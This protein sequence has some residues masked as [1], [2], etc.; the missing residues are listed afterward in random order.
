MLLVLVSGCVNLGGGAG[1]GAKPPTINSF[2]AS[3]SP[4]APGDTSMLS[5]N[6]SGATTIS[7]NQGIGNVALTGSRTVTPS[8]T[9]VYILTATNA[10][11]STTAT[12]EV[13]VSAAVA[14]PT[15]PAP[16][17]TPPVPE[18]TPVPQPSADLPV[19]N[20]FN[21]NPAFI[22]SGGTT[23]LSWGV[24][25]ATQV[26]IDQGIGNVGMVG[27][28]PASPV[29]TTNYTLTATNAA[30]WSSVTIT[31][32]V[33]AAPPPANK[34][35]LVITDITL[36]G[37]TIKYVIKNQGTAAA[38]ASTAQLVIDGVAKATGA[39]GPLS[40]GASSTLSFGYSY[41]CS[42]TSDTVAVG[43]DVYNVVDEIN[44]GN[45]VL[46]K[47][48]S[49]LIMLP[50]AFILSFKPDLI[51]TDI[52]RDGVT[53]RYRIK[54]QGSGNAVASTT[55]LIVDG[56]VKAHDNVP[57]LVAGAEST[58]SFT[59]VLPFLPFHTFHVTVR[60]DQTNVVTESNEA[61]NERT[62]SMHW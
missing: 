40:A 32:G 53:I 24:A 2:N 11:G 51:I 36:S 18:P 25:N 52:W 62:E 48:W 3:P 38:G 14:T 26:T 54:N 16:T 55:R 30:G 57:A 28:A 15:P 37:S 8:A 42:G 34:P 59:Y 10:A 12:A 9:T 29:A 44:E 39:V 17:P 33:G 49:C 13:V 7:I 4:I 1:C 21:A 22:T 31:V 45:N 41:T 60:A 58:R 5:W 47:S 50:P 61:N 20:Y 19:I 27:T 46:T 23:T 6:V 43:A 35:D 56:V